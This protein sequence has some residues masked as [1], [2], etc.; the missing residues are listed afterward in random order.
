MT[1]G[2]PVSATMPARL[3]ASGVSATSSHWMPSAPPAVEPQPVTLD[4]VD[5]TAGRVRGPGDERG[6][7]VGG[8]A[9]QRAAVRLIRFRRSLCDVEGGCPPSPGTGEPAWSDPAS[10]GPAAVEFPARPAS[11]PGSFRRIGRPPASQR[12]AAK[13]IKTRKYRGTANESAPPVHQIGDR[14]SGL[15]PA[16][17]ELGLRPRPAAL[18]LR[19]HPFQ[20]GFGVQRLRHRLRVVRPVGGAVQHA[21]RRVTAAAAAPRFP[22][23]SAA[24]CGAAPSA[25]GPGR[26]RAPRPGSPAASRCTS[27]IA[28]PWRHPYVGQPPLADQRQ[29]VADARRVHLDGQVVAVRVG[30]RH[31]RGGVTHPE[32]DLQHPRRS[33]AE[34]PVQVEGSA[35]AVQP[36]SGRTP[37]TARS[38]RRR[39][40]RSSARVAGGRCGSAGLRRSRS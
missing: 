27:S 1:S 39:A 28:S 17:G 7:V 37:A 24:A 3:S 33:P 23:G 15:P 18:V 30:R 40:G 14:P 19:R 11:R 4:E 13:E 6:Q 35:V 10:A 36:R 21:A 8:A 22:A 26:T 29:Q 34:Q 2:A 32:A 5:Q 20:A 12:K 16:P 31:R 38:W 25:T 9:G